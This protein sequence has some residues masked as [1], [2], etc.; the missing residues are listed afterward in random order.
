MGVII[1]GRPNI[2]GVIIIGDNIYGGGILIVVVKIIT[3]DINYI[4]KHS[5]IYIS[6]KI[7]NQINIINNQLLFPLP[8]HVQFVANNLYAHNAIA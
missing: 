4:Y 6:L 7:I 1:V 3:A 5:K 8:K 2:Y